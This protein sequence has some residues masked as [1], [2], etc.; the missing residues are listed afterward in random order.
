M[1]SFSLSFKVEEEKPGH[2]LLL[3]FL[4]PMSDIT[5]EDGSHSLPALSPICR[6]SR[7]RRWGPARV[8]QGMSGRPSH[9]V[10]CDLGLDLQEAWKTLEIMFNRSFQEASSDH[11]ASHGLPKASP[12]LGGSPFLWG[13]AQQNSKCWSS[14]TLYLSLWASKRLH[15]SSM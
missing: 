12:A 15:S 6:M 10:S 1:A 7:P 14:G 9:L 11:S 4:C 3:S 2:R 5:T 13:G 8:P